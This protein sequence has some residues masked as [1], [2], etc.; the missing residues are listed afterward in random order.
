M[1]FQLSIV[2]K[3]PFYDFINKSRISDAMKLRV[4]RFESPFFFVIHLTKRDGA[5]SI[6]EAYL[7]ISVLL[8][9]FPI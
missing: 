1:L 8:M 6:N 5:P 7:G 2:K 9:S 4:V 3:K